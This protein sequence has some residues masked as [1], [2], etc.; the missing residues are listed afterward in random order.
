AVCSLALLSRRADHE[1]VAQALRSAPR[2][3]LLIRLRAPRELLE[4]RLAERQRNQSRI[5]QLF[6]LD[7]KT[8]FDSIRIIEQLSEL[9]RQDGRPLI[10]I[11]STDRHALH[12]AV[13]RIEWELTGERQFDEAA[14]GGGKS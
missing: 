14:S 3:D 10:C 2:A 13:N 11:D 4:A 8:T 12:R 5:E 6:E 7:L 1:L 9:I